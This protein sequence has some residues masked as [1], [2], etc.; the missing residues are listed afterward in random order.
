ML[1]KSTLREIR[2]T[3]GRFVAILAIVALGVSFFSG[4]KVTRESMVSTADEFLSTHKLYDYELASSLG[5]DKDSVASVTKTDGVRTAEGSISKDIIVTSR[6][7]A[8][9]VFKALSITKKTNLLKL[10]SGRM[11]KAD[12]ECVVDSRFFKKSAIGDYVTLSGS[13][14]SDDKSAFKYR[15]YKIV[16]LVTSPLYLNYERGTSSLGSGSIKAFFYI[17]KGGFDLDYYTEIYVLLD[18]DSVIY[19]DAYKDAIKDAKPA[20]KAAAAAA[21]AQRRSDLID[22]AKSKLAKQN[23]KYNKS[24]DKYVSSKESTYAKLNSALTKIENG[25]A[26]IK[27]N[28]AKLSRN[29]K[30]LTQSKSKI[31]AGLKTISEKQ[32]QLEA[33]RQYMTDAEYQAAKAQLD[34]QES[35]LKSQLKK[36]ESGLI[37]V[38]NGEK[39][40]AVSASTLQAS[41]AEYNSGKAKADSQFAKA[42]AQLDKGRKA[43]NR[44]E[45]KIEKISA[46][47][48]YALTRSINIGY[49]SFENDSQIVDGVAKVFPLFFFLVAALVCMTTMTRMID[50]E[51]TQ[52]GVFKA[53]GY[54][55]RAVLG[56]YMFYS[57]SA[58]IIGAVSGFFIGCYLFPEVIWKAYGMMYNFS[59][60]IN[61]T[62]NW[63]L[64]AISML[65]AILCSMGATWLSCSSDFTVAPAQLIRPKS[66]KSGKRILLE[67]IG[68]LWNRIGFLYKVSLRNIFRYK[69]RFFMMVL[70][71][72]GCTALLIAGFGINDTVKNIAVFQ[73]SEIMKYDYSVTFDAN[74]TAARQA[75]FKAYMKD[76]ANS[77]YFVNESSVDLDSGSKTSAVSLI[78]ADGRGFGDFVDLHDGSTSIKYPSKGKAVVCRKLHKQ[79][80]VDVGD[81]VTLRQGSKKMT[82]TVSAICENFVNNY[83][84]INDETYEEGFGKAPAQKTAYV[85]VAA[86]GSDSSGTEVVAGSGASNTAVH[87]SAAHCDD[88][89]YAGG[90]NINQDMQNRVDNM[91]S[92]L[93]AVI[94]LVILSAG[95]L[96]FIVL[97]NLTNI[98]ITERI[99]EIATI[100]V[101]GFYPREISAYVY[102]ENFFLTGISA[103]VG[104]PLGKWLLDFV[105]SQINVDLVYFD[106][107]ITFLSYIWSVLL[108]FVFAI[109]VAAVMYKKIT[110]ISMTESLKSIE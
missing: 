87:A 37:Q 94:I 28:K 50:E 3:L 44:A 73:Y 89:K 47:K 49:V 1:K 45:N 95:A 6:D 74:M 42:K 10:S 66:P 51:R 84:Y 17:N 39:K 105:I 102:R 35:S 21:T 70:G 99:R 101:L 100:E 88:Y 48:S 59:G 75:D 53:L 90:T 2:H 67:R 32:A 43:L 62:V 109:I 69:K 52:I 16:G 40:L 26:Q 86:P 4:L 34:Q 27:S 80:G 13:N 61:Y 38:K 63:I 103:L 110:N 91:M 36:V 18:N 31:E 19:S 22:T 72:S 5:Y 8:E 92:S 71:I 57:G 64:F 23:I 55:N 77:I 11:P 46:G 54:S 25:E 12:N 14:T 78:T 98:N 24:Y 97:Y 85:S 83:V 29:Y 30:T 58:A 56:K 41:R 15:K 104:I 81:K 108:T 76:D 96:A 33:N 9:R 106:V 7:K 93:N 20:M 79:Y 60:T 107:R 68:F 82:V 65:V